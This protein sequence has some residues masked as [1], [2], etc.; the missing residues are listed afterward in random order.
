VSFLIGGDARVGVANHRIRR[1]FGRF[2]RLQ[3]G[4]GLPEATFDDH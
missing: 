4:A 3:R 1:G 2:V